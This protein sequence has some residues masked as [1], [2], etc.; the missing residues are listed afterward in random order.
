MLL[1]HIVCTVPLQSQKPFSEGQRSWSTL[2][3]V[4]GFV[5]QFGGFHLNKA[6]IVGL[7][8]SPNAYRTFMSNQHD[9]IAAIGKQEHS[10]TSIRVSLYETVLESAIHTTVQEL[11]SSECV[12]QLIVGSPDAAVFQNHPSAKNILHLPCRDLQNEGNDI[13][14]SLHSVSAVA[15]HPKRNL[16]TPSLSLFLLAPWSVTSAL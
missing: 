3:Q 15:E 7:W 2:Q 5:A 11:L 4:A 14:V 16:V 12:M 13:V 9:E 8:E 1:K 6:H 10:Y